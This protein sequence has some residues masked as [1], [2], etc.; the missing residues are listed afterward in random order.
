MK[1]YKTETGLFR[2]RDNMT[3]M[4]G[5]VLLGLG[6]SFCTFLFS[7]LYLSWINKMASPAGKIPTIFLFSTLL[8]GVSSYTLE[9]AGKFLKQDNFLA[10]RRMLG[11]TLFL[12]TAFIAFQLWG[13]AILQTKGAYLIG[14]FFWAYLYLLSGFHILHVVVGLFFLAW[15]L[16]VSHKNKT[17]INSFVYNIN[18]PNQLKW[19]LLTRY[20]HF[21]GI[22]WGVVFLFLRLS[23]AT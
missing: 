5:I 11:L 3:V 18:P 6:L 21:I 1:Q 9:Q 10:Y 13:W 23:N 17:Y 22:V 15:R 20:W 19:K 2:R 8:I 16:R 7:F 12:G 14:S 4:L